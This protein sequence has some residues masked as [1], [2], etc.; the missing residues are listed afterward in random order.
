MASRALKITLKKTSIQP[1][2]ST[3]RNVS[4]AVGESTIAVLAYQ[5][6]RERGSPIGSDQ[7][8]WFEAER[9]LKSGT[10]LA[11]STTNS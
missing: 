3:D 7:D 11:Q 10:R 5:L 1:T 6:W 9:K 2:D 4:G 8:D